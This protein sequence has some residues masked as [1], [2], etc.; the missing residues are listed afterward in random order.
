MI[1]TLEDYKRYAKID[2]HENSIDS[3]LTELAESAEETLKNYL[4]RP[5]ESTAYSEEI[6]DG[7]GKSILT[8]R[9]FPV[10]AITTIKVWDATDETWDTLTTADYT[11]LIVHSDN[12]SIYAEDYI[13]ET[14]IQNYKISYTAGYTASTM[15]EDLKL[16]L[17]RLFKAYYDESPYGNDSLGKNSINDGSAGNSQ[18]LGIDVD[19]EDRILKKVIRYRC[20]NV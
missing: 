1:L 8:L 9:K 13:F 4:E 11:R 3:I 6:Y 20:I 10:T 2:R 15:P 16:C 12:V 19:I 14:G 5:L 17:R 18:F 7:N